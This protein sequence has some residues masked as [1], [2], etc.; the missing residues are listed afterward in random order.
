METNTVNSSLQFVCTLS[1]GPRDLRV[2]VEQLSQ[3]PHKRFILENVLISPLFTKPKTMRLLK[4]LKEEGVIKCLYFDS[5]GYQAQKGQIPYHRLYHDLLSFYRENRWADFYVLPDYPPTSLDTPEQVQQKVRIT[6]EYGAQFLWELPSE[7][8]HKTIAV[9]QGRSLQEI[10]YCIAMYRRLNVSHLGYG[11]F[12]TCG[13]QSGVNVL[14]ERSIESIA[15]ILRSYPEAR[16]HVFGV[17]NPPTAYLLGRMGVASFDSSGWIKAAGYGNIYFPFT[18]AYNV[19]FRRIERGNGALNEE[20]FLLLKDLTGHDCGF[21]YDFREIS[22]SRDKRML[23]NLIC[24]A[25]TVETINQGLEC[26]PSVVSW[27]GD[28]QRFLGNGQV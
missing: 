26:S 17:G 2:V 7:L 12:G 15:F 28:C 14:D 24:M 27:M 22:A 21:C 10:S 11:S 18:R 6:V 4:R 25:E 13:L 1:I 8:R 16:L 5:G 20:T 9:V 23:H 3:I 19:S